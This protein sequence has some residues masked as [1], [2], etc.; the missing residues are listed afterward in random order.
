V[1][2]V[3]AALQDPS[4][5]FE[6]FASSLVGSIVPTLIADV[7]RASDQYERRT[8]GPLERLKSRVPGLRSGLEPR[9]D[10][11]GKKIKTANFLEVMADATRPGNASAPN[12]PVTLELRRLMDEGQTATWTQ[13]GDRRG[14]DSL[15]PEEN[16][17]LWQISGV[18]AKKLVAEAMNSKEYKA[19]DDELKAKYITRMVNAAKDEAKG[20][21]VARAV[22]GLKGTA[23]EEKLAEMKEEGLLTNKA[24]GFYLDEIE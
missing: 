5:S 19:F 6:G 8:A 18:T 13:V 1:N 23:L 16:T 2:R 11:F 24:F 14:Y 10:T 17:Y 20:K 22:K 15:T 4:R 21:A 3:I 12:D 7:A 9:V